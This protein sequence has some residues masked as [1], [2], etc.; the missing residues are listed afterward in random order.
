MSDH[1]RLSPPTQ[2]RFEARITSFASWVNVA[3]PEGGRMY[4]V[5]FQR[6]DPVLL[7]YFI[8]ATTLSLL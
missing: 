4:L 6:K 2:N 8:I 3:L 1:R 5:N 7:K